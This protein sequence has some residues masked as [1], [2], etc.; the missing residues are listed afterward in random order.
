[1]EARNLKIKVLVHLVSN[2]G[3]LSDSQMVNGVRELSGTFFNKGTNP[4]HNPH[5][6]V[7][8]QRPNT[9]Y[10]PIGEVV[11]NILAS[12]EHIGRRIFLGYI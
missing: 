10:H 2:E 1:M 9:K 11:F 8:S 5:D 7:T 6:L 3:L 4:I 12:L